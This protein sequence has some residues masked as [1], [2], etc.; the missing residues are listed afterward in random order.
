MS[1]WFA[2]GLA[3]VVQPWAPIAAGAATVTAAG[4][5]LILG[6]V[7]ARAVNILR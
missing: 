3:P 5:L 7:I 4:S 2:L 6:L 1:P